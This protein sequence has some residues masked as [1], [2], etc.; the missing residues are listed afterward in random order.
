MPRRTITGA[1]IAIR[2]DADTLLAVPPMPPGTPSAVRVKVFELVLRGLVGEAQI[3][4]QG[5]SD[6][7]DGSAGA[8]DRL[9]AMISEAPYRTAKVAA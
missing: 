8:R 2:K 5:V 1:R 4:L 3:V 9:A 6:G 7:L